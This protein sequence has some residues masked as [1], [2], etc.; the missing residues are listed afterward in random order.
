MHL[1]QLED[2]PAKHGWLIR[3]VHE[4]DDYRVSATWEIARGH[5]TAAGLSGFG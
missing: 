1:R 4:G 3:D 5:A 2:Q